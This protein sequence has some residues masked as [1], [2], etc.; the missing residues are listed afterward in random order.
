MPDEDR[1]KDWKDELTLQ[2]FKGPQ[3]QKTTNLHGFFTS[4]AEY[5]FFTAL[6]TYLNKN[7]MSPEM[8]SEFWKLT[9]TVEKE[10]EVMCEDDEPIQREVNV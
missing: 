5:D 6:W 3:K 1:I 10:E 2:D 8:H 4:A 9:F 7:H